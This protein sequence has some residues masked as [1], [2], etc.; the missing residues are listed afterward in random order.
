M[1]LGRHKRES[2]KVRALKVVY[3]QSP[4]MLEEPEHLAIMKKCAAQLVRRS[5]GA[6]HAAASWLNVPAVSKLGN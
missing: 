6:A 4:E 2:K 1:V 3:L 5:C